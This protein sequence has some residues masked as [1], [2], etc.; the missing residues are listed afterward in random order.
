[1]NKNKK[2]TIFHLLGWEA[3]QVIQQI[4][5]N[6]IDSV[7]NWSYESPRGTVTFH[8][9]THCAYAPLYRGKIEAAENE[10]CKLSIS[11]KINISAD[12]HKKI[13]FSRPEGEY[14]RWRNNYFSI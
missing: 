9:E 3:A 13:F 1:K 4:L 12:E 5:Q 14:T 11:E 10:K 6:G 8:P 7:S 2:P